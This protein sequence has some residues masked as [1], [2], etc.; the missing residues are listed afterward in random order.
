MAR[1]PKLGGKSVSGKKLPEFTW[2]AD[3]IE[4]D[5]PLVSLFKSD[6]DA[7]ALFVWVDCDRYKNRWC[8]VQVVRSNLRG[9]LNAE[10][11]LRDLFE[12]AGD[13]YFFDVGPSGR[14]SNFVVST[15]GIVPQSYLPAADS[16]LDD[17]VATDAARRLASEGT[18][19]CVFNLDGELYLDDISAIPKLIQQL[20]SFHYGLTHSYRPAVRDKL[21]EIMGKWRGGVNAVNIFTGLKSVIPSIHRPQITELHYASPGHIKLDALPD[22]TQHID[23]ALNRI[24]DDQNFERMQ[25]LYSSIYD[26]FKREELSGF[27]DVDV[28]KATQITNRQSGDLEGFF[29][30]FFDALGWSSY[31]DSFRGLDPSPLARMRVLLAYYRRLRQL[32]E[33]VGQ[34]KLR[35]QS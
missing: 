34:G 30:V 32:R 1:M 7:D 3:L 25:E 12:Q 31:S 23:A 35:L 29:N 26:Y 4:F 28:S 6:R 21:T 10:I 33:F 15:I 8:I 18:S 22:L 5:G 24:S 20:Y 17:S 13:L 14:R 9:Y 16:M 19:S 11:A 27:D 2:N